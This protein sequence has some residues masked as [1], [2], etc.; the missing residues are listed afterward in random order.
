ME[1]LCQ[2]IMAGHERRQALR[3]QLREGA[4]E[5]KHETANMLRGFRKQFE[6]FRSDFQAGREAWQKAAATLAKKRRQTTR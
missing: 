4:V 6:T 2:D 1:K 3:K 5:L